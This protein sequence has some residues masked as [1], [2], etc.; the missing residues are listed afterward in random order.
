MAIFKP[1]VE[2]RQD[3]EREER[4]TNDAADDD[5]GERALH[6]GPGAGGEG[7]RHKA[8]RGDEGGHQHGA[9]PRKGAFGHGVEDRVALL[10]ELVEVG[11]EHEA[12]EDGHAAERRRAR[13]S[14]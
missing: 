1:V 10:A 2:H 13:A 11:H 14:R 9:E 4:G 12:I 8:E 6:F 5:R 3:D 7:H